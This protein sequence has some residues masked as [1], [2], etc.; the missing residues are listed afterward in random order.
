MKRALSTFAFVL[1]LV[2]TLTFAFNTQNVG[3]SG[4][5]YIR[6]DGSI[7]PP[8]APISTFDNVTYALTD[9]ITSDAHGIVIERDNIV[10]DGAGYTVQGTMTSW[11]GIHLIERS[12]V[13]IKNM[14]IIAFSYGICLSLSSSITVSGN[15]ITN[16]RDFGVLISGTSNSAL[17]NN[18][19]SGNRFDFKVEGDTL[20]EYIHDVDVSNTVD[21]KPI[22]YLVNQTNLIIDS[23]TYLNIGYLALVNS[24][25]ITVNGLDLKNNGQ[26]LLFAYT[27]NSRITNNNIANNEYGIDV[28]YSSNNSILGNNI[29]NNYYGISL[30]WS[31]E[32][33]ISGNNITGSEGCG[34]MLHS[35]SNNSIAGNNITTNYQCGIWFGFSSGNSISGNNITEN[36]WCGIYLHWY[37]SNNNIIGNIFTNDGLWVFYAYGN[38]VEDNLVNG[39]PLVYLEGVSD[40]NVENAGQVILVNCDSIRVENLNLSCTDV[41]IELWNTNN[42]KI[43]ENNITNNDYYGIDLHLSS[44]NSIVRNNITNDYSGVYLGSSSNNSIDGNNITESIYFGIDLHDSSNHNSISGNNITNNT[45]GVYLWHS[46]FNNTVSGNNITNNTYGVTLYSSSPN[47]VSGNNITN[48]GE[49]VRLEQSSYNNTVS[50]NNMTNNGYGVVLW[51]SSNNTV[52]GN[53]I[54][55]NTYGVYLWYSSL[56]NVSG[57]NITNNVFGLRLYNSSNN[58]FYHSNFINNTQQVFIEMSGYGNAWDDD[59][60]SGGNYWSDYAG[61]DLFSGPYQNET[62]SDGMGDSPYIVEVDNQDNYP[63]MNPWP[64]GWK[65]DFAGPTNHPIVDFA[66]Y[67]GSLYAAADNK[68]YVKQG[69]TWNAMNAPTYVTSLESGTFTNRVPPST[70]WNKTYGGT[71][72]DYAYSVVQTI[73]KGYALAGLTGSVGAGDYDFWLVKTDSNG[74]MQWNM[75]YGGTSEDVACALVQTVDGGYA[76]A[77]DTYSFGAGSYDAWLVKTD[78][79]GNALWNMTYGGTSTDWAHALVQTAD[80]GYA[81][82]GYTGSF[83]AGSGDFWLV[84]TDSSGNAQWNKTYGGTDSDGACALVQ[85]VDGGYALAGFTISY[86][87]GSYD[88]WL[89]KTDANGN[90]QWNQAYG[91]TGDDGAWSVIQTVDGGYAVTGYTGSYGAGGD[92]WLIKTEP[93]DASVGELV[94]GGDEGLYCYDGA[95]FELAFSVPTYIKVL[96]VYNDTLYAGTVLDNPPKLYYCNGPSENPASW[97]VDTGFSTV[98]SFSGAFGSIDS[99]EVFS[100]VMYVSCGGKVYSSNGTGWSI[101]KSY[102]DV[103]GF[104]D[105]TVYNGKLYLATRDQGWRKPLYQGGTG[106]SGRVIEYDGAS[107]TTVLDHDYWVYSLE[108]YDGKLYAGTANKILTYNGTDWETSFNATEGAYY[109]ISLITYD[110]KIYAGMGNGYIFADPAPP[111]ASLETPTVPE[112]SSA[113]VLAVFMALTMLAVAL[114]RKK[115]SRRFS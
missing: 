91:G 47:T 92:F 26:G 33:N 16:S 28:P 87:A 1:L 74:N 38:A 111:K 90:E 60:P 80:G 6:A 46:S 106:F 18:T 98:L 11:T 102:D 70:E 10:V 66:V 31:S 113:T 71:G 41:G 35:S 5:I 73:D 52:S 17:R 39:K 95:S 85:T 75:T 77:G 109:A 99:F 2:S 13:T 61:V 7:E 23:S 101:A 76:L 43:A 100:D 27:T 65:L 21:G 22:Y 96:G 45:Y 84:K 115:R 97:H 114:T 8:D 24:A 49:G 78:S 37:S 79:E 14:E 48:N 53:D 93:Y 67:N 54:T 88:F 105:M 107:W 25:N 83:G 62:G 81:I 103:Y 4:T 69:T 58:K 30:A 3:A 51:S 63:L 12:N 110:G 42:T 112:F 57:N 94:L 56:N 104:P 64:S 86:G 20:D 72:N 19:I 89:V 68:L 36:G 82:A 50:G 55:N 9:H 15:N 44:N 29:T 59:Y 32:N 34:I 108:V 40:V